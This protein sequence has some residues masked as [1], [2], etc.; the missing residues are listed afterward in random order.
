MADVFATLCDW[1]KDYDTVYELRDQFSDISFKGDGWYTN[2]TD[3]ILIVGDDW[4]CRYRAYV[5]NIP[6]ARESVLKKIQEMMEA[7]NLPV[8]R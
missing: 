1:H 2:G 4:D 3:T 8:H 7:I 5:W 6:D